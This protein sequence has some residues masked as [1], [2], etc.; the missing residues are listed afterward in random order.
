VYDAIELLQEKWT[1]H[2]VRALLGGPLGF[3]ELSRTVGG[4]NPATLA[5]RL[6]HLEAVGIVSK[7]VV[8]VM[9][10]RSS[11]AL[12]CSGFELQAVIDAIDGWARANLHAPEAPGAPVPV[13]A[14]R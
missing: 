1:L 11:Y 10:P 7:T 6:S 5:A 14:A 2:V 8:S 13:A 12:T 4:V 9:P 3:N